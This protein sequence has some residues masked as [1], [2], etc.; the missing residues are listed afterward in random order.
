MK[1]ILVGVDGSEPAARAVQLAA[2]IAL[3]FGARLTLAYVVAPLLLPPD[4]YGLTAAGVE[5]Q[6]EA[7][8]RKLLAS[9]ITTLG[10]PGLEVDTTVLIGAPAEKLAEAAAANDVGLVVVGSRGRGAVARMLLGSVS[11]RLVHISPKP[12]L[13]AH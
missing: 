6:N 7:F 4:A 9:A 5:Q 12:V 8:G 11:D 13:I 1:R 3:R 2:E 10:E